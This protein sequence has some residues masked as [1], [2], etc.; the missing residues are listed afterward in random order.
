MEE[1]KGSPRTSVSFAPT[2]VFAKH[3]P[4]EVK[5]Q[6]QKFNAPSWKVPEGDEQQKAPVPAFAIPSQ[7]QNP[8]LEQKEREQLTRDQYLQGIAIVAGIFVAGVVIGYYGSRYFS[9]P[10][11]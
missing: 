10:P 11:A 3:F 6:A 7:L 1:I 8:L 9:A 2:E 4:D 5:E